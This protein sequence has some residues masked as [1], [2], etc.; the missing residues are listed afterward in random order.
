METKLKSKILQIIKWLKRVAHKANGLVDIT[1]F[2]LIPTSGNHR[3]FVS[4]IFSCFATPSDGQRSPAS[5]RCW[6]YFEER[7]FFVYIVF[8]TCVYYKAITLF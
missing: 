7:F 1:L 5:G 8:F 2:L 4:Y 6:L 3:F